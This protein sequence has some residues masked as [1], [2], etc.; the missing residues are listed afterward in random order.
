M[1]LKILFVSSGSGATLAYAIQAV[2][3]GIINVDFTK[4]IVDRDCGAIEVGQRFDIPVIDINPNRRK[5][6]KKEISDEIGFYAEGAD[7]ICLSFAR[8]IDESLIQKFNNRIIN[9]HPSILPAYKS[10]GAIKRARD[11]GKSMFTGGTVHF[12]DKEV[13]NGIA[14]IQS[15]VPLVAE[16]DYHSLTMKIWHLQKKN[17]TQV[18]H[19]FSQDRIKVVNRKCFVENAIYGE[20]PTSPKIEL[21]LPD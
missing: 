18:F 7:I 17:V 13:D 2:K 15:I 16:D 9:S 19:W 20:L 8:L 14:I 5:Q 1:T 12:V 3:N 10:F 21:N 4:I 6:S 11:E